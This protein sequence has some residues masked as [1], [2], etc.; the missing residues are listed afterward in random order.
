MLLLNSALIT[1][2]AGFL[3][4]HLATK[5]LDDGNRVICVDNFQSGSRQNIEH[6]CDYKNF[7]LISHDICVPLRV[8]VD[9]IY[10]F[11]GFV[12]PVFE[13][14]MQ[15]EMAET[16]VLGALNMLKLAQQMD[17]RIFQASS[18]EVYDL[19]VPAPPTG[20]DWA[21]NHQIRYVPSYA[22]SKRYAET[23]FHKYAKN[24]RIDIKM[25]R[26]F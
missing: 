23:L 4:S 14:Q 3:G 26:I 13:K 8:E 22:A 2:G 21:R 11:A 19:P 10:N 5:L 18:N 16:S 15:K 25:A 20:E 24:Y 1:G 17:C 6:L 7:E 12:S 9:E